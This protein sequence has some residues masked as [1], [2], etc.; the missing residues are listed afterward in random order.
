MEKM[1]EFLYERRL[2]TVLGVI[3]ASGILP[4]EAL[5]EEEEQGDYILMLYTLAVI[6]TTIFVQWGAQKLMKKVQH[7]WFGDEYLGDLEPRYFAR[8][9][10]RRSTWRR[11]S[12][13]TGS[14]TLWI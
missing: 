9:R 12:T 11:S 6:V 1:V 2:T 4:C 3:L 8:W 14:P 10:R 13:S 5:R 7:R